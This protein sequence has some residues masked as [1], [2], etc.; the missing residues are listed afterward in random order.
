MKHTLINSFHNTSAVVVVP[1]DRAVI[2]KGDWGVGKR[3]VLTLTKSQVD[4]ADRKLCGMADC[5]C[6][7]IVAWGQRWEN[8]TQDGELTISYPLEGRS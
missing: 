1:D 7:G 2:V 5:S 6:G 4:R 3:Q 8:E